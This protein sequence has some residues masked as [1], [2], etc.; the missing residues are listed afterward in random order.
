MASKVS[1]L[2]FIANAS[3][4]TKNLKDVAADNALS[5]HPYEADITALIENPRLDFDLRTVKLD[6]NLSGSYIWV[7][8]ELQLKELGEALS[9][10]RVFAVDTEQHS[11]R[12]FLGFTALVQVSYDGLLVGILALDVQITSFWVTLTCE[13]WP[14]FYWGNRLSDRHNCLTRFHGS[15]SCSFC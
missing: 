3:D 7:Q 10:E 9:K 11:L 1:S 14:D 15:S 6:L 12:S 2:S 5:T 13:F 4:I 8:T